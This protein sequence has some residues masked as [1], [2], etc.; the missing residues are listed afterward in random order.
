MPHLSSENRIYVVF[1]NS[2]T[3][4]YNTGKRAYSFFKS[5]FI[6]GVPQN[7]LFSVYL[8]YRYYA[9]RIS[10]VSQICQVEYIYV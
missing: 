6:K 1:T 4:F 2:S 5:E 3:K 10:S 7:T 9:E 8:T